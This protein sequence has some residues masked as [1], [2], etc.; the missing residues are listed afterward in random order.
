M[1][2]CFLLVLL[3]FTGA[4]QLISDIVPS[5]G[6]NLTRNCFL[7]GVSAIS[8]FAFLSAHFQLS[9]LIGAK[10][11]IPLAATL[12]TLNAFLQSVKL[13]RKGWITQETLM[14]GMLQLV[15]E[16]FNSTGDPSK[17]LSIMTLVDVF[18]SVVSFFYPHPV[19]FAYLYISYYSVKRV[20][21]RFFN[22]QWDA[23]LLETL[24]LSMLLSMAYDD[25]TIAMC[26]WAFKALLFRLMFGS[27]VVKFFSRD[28][29]WNKSCTAMSYH[30]LTQP[31]P[32]KLG[33]YVHKYIP[34]SMF[35][36]LT[37][38]SLVVELV[39]PVF[40]VLNST[41]FNR[42]CCAAYLLLQASIAATGYYGKSS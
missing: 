2:A 19:L 42:F 35:R 33:M 28:E 31:L 27:G 34:Q 5:G 14:A 18:V 11:L 17:Q 7:A 36:Y 9:G 24:F 30:F 16:K 40:S 12:S 25:Q 3:G 15:L 10:G 6:L 38:G 13:R 29:S 39:V 21:G 41:G 22:F 4:V 37:V 23:L 8:V 20:G 26:M 32:S 1:D